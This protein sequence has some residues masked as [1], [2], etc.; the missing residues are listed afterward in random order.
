MRILN[1]SGDNMRTFDTAFFKEELFNTFEINGISSLL[2]DEKAEKFAILT[3]IM[4]E[5]NQKYNLTAI[6]EVD[7]IILLHYADSIMSASLFGKSASVIDVGCGAGFPSVPLAICRPD[8]KITA[9]D[10]TAKKVNYVDKISKELSLNIK[11]VCARA[12]DA[13]KANVNNSFRERFDIATAR[14]VADLSVLSEL[15]LP[16]V[17][18]GGCFAVMKGKNGKEELER[19]K[20]GISILGGHIVSE[21]EFLLTDTNGEAYERVSALVKKEKHT[22]AQYPRSYSQI[23]K[24]PL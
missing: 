18:V 9:L 3:E 11:A 21:N 2:D 14:A 24:K 5:E 10:S 20:K 17:K 4:L 12:E 6:K 19:A 16:L 23:T 22:D 13:A 15:C 1:F 8:L 7:K